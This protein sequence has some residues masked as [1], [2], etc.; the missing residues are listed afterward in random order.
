M[1]S[2]F[3]LLNPEE[4]SG[5]HPKAVTGSLEG[6]PVHEA[7]LE[8]CGKRPPSFILNT[9][10]GPEKK[11]I[12]AFAGEW[13]SA[14][15]EGCRFYAEIFS[16][17]IKE[18]A[19]LVVVS[20]GGFPKDINMIQ[21]HKSMEYAS[22]ALKPGGVMI[23]LA[24]C[25]DGYGNATFFN[26][27][28]YRTCQELESALRKRYEINGQTAWSVKEKAERFRIVL[29]SQLPPEEVRTMGMIPALSLKEA[30]ELAA[31]M[32]PEDYRAYLIPEG[33]NVLPVPEAS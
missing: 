12:A 14:H 7:M 30:M 2:H 18:R 11:I 27:F 6:N 21:S 32:L 10:L 13:C 24:E 19:D 5:R 23:L 25:R 31:P 29:V 3:S 26:W 28:G 16:A 20:C 33:G 15:L 9:V 1:A 4:G 17:P 22:R 8:A